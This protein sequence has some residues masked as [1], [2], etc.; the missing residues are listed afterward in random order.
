MIQKRYE[1]YCQRLKQD[2]GL[3][4]R[5]FSCRHLTRPSSPGRMCEHERVTREYTVEI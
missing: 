4:F 1:F 5:C 2:I 3:G